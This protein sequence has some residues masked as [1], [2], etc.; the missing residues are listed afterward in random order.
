[1]S[2]YANKEHNNNCPHEKK[3][4]EHYNSGARIFNLDLI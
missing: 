4:K 2:G 1:M 3:E